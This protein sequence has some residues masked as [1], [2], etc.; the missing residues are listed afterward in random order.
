MSTTQTKSTSQ[1]S[2]KALFDSFTGFVQA[3]A[4]VG[5]LIVAVLGLNTF[6]PLVAYQTETRRVEAN[7]VASNE[8]TRDVI[9]WWAQQLR[10]YNGIMKEIS[11][12]Q[13]TGADIVFRVAHSESGP[14]IL[15]L[16]A[17]HPNAVSRRYAV[18]VNED[19]P[20]RKRIAQI[21]TGELYLELYPTEQEKMRGVVDRFARSTG[22]LIDKLPA[23][24][25]DERMELDQLSRSMFVHS[26]D[27]REALTQLRMLDV[28][29]SDALD[30]VKI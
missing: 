9:E 20:I 28:V 16:D 21:F 18:I 6:A 5:I 1:P 23:P 24:H 8:F 30:L 14:D 2:K 29:I 19:R 3:G 10:G 17:R 12:R 11:S 15:I 27:R 25:A 7:L 13:S 4:S 26:T 22:T